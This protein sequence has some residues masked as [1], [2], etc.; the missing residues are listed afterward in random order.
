MPDRDMAH[1]EEGRWEVGDGR[2]E[3]EDGRDM[4]CMEAM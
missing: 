3:R 4:A 2:R 1:V